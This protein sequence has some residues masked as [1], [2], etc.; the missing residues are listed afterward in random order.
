MPRTEIRPF[1]RKQTQSY[2]CQIA[3][4]QIAL[5]KDKKAAERKCRELVKNRQRLNEA[6]LRVKELIA[7]YLEWCLKHRAIKTYNLAQYFL[8]SFTATISDR[9]RI[10]ELK[11]RHANEWLDAANTWNST[12][13]HDATTV[14]QRVFNW[15]LEERVIDRHPFP[16]LASKPPRQRREVYYSPEQIDAIF[17]AVKDQNFRD[18]LTFTAETGCRPFE[19]RI[20]EAIHC[21]LE[22]SLIVFHTEESKGKKSRRTI[23]L[24][25]KA[26]EICKRLSDKHSTGPIF[27]NLRGNPWTKDAVNCRFYRL[28]QKLGFQGSLCLYGFRHT[29]ATDAL[30]NGV[31]SIVVGELMGHKDASQV[32]RTYQHVAKNMAFLKSAA[33]QAKNRDASG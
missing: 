26:L 10:D 1:F 17:A 21:Q 14:L 5:G 23:V 15:A 28:K 4:K 12:S 24:T 16:K 31:D 6:T 13:K 27:R 20:I 33:E 3:G 19:G 29:F 32:A 8:S 18:L 2:Y 9:L 7:L 30:L 22:H 11:P 25:N